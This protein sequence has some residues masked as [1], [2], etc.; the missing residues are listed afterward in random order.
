MMHWAMSPAVAEA[1]LVSDVPLDEPCWRER[2]YLAAKRVLD[3][4]LGLVLVL[5]TAPIMLFAG[6]G[7]KLTSPGPVLFRQRRGGLNA[8]PFVMYKFRSMLDGAEADRPRLAKRNELTE[9]PVFK[10][11]QDPRLTPI[12]WF[13]RQTSIDELPQLFN[14]LAGDMTLVGPRPLPL[15]E[16]S[17]ATP[18]ERKRLQVKPGLTCLW[19]I[20]GRCEIPYNEWMLLD[21]YYVH[22]RS[23]TLDL[24]ILIKTLPAVLSRR[25]AY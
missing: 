20:S 18:A 2:C 11:Q 21:L 10:L 15:E 25:G 19:Q 6:I 24:E 3:I 23:L 8:K 9:G 17:L 22:H 14:V 13:L 16:V 12:G 7:I 5:A 1:A 4:G